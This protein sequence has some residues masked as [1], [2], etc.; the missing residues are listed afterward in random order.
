MCLFEDVHVHHDILYTQMHPLLKLTYMNF[1]GG[2]GGHLFLQTN[3]PQSTETHS[4]VRRIISLQVLHRVLGFICEVIPWWPQNDLDPS[5]SFF[6][7]QSTDTHS[8]VGRIISSQ[9][10]HTKLGFICEVIPW[11]PQNDL[12]PYF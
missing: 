10:L 5:F 7:V 9:V 11:W 12:D 2:G 8:L 4:W 3:L 6:S 1:T